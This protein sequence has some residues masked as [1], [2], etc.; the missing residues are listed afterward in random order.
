MTFDFDP[1]TKPQVALVNLGLFSLA[2]GILAPGS[3]SLG[4]L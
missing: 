3:A 2:N 4:A 1:S